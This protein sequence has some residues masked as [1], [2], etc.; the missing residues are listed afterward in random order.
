M[1]QLVVFFVLASTVAA[2][3]PGL[4]RFEFTGMEMASSVRIVLYAES[5]AVAKAAADAAFARFRQLNGIMSDYDP[6]SEVRRLS[7]SSGSGKAVEV[8]DD[9]WRVLCRS[10]ELSELSDGAFD[11]T[12]GPVVRLWRR[13]RRE[14]VLP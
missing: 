8:G 7:A 5:E 11:V 4:K 6:E 2:A 9:L 12:I 13:A 14:E 1:P 3:E 10:K